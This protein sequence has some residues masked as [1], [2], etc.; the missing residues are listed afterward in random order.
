[1]TYIQGQELAKN[2]T[3]IGR[4][5]GCEICPLRH[6]GICRALNDEVLENFKKISR[7]RF[8]RQGNTI[9]HEGDESN[10]F[11]SIVFGL[12]KLSKN[13]SGGRQHIV[14]LLY[15]TAFFGQRLESHHV[16][17]AQAVSDVELCCYPR[18][19]FERFVKQHPELEHAVFEM[20]IQQLDLCRNRTLILARKNSL[21]RVASFLMMTV[22]RNPEI[23]SKPINGNSARIKLPFTRA[24]LADYLGLTL[25]TVSR[26]LSILRKRRVIELRSSRDVIVSDIGELVSAASIE[27]C[28]EQSEGTGA[29]ASN[30]YRQSLPRDALGPEPRTSSPCILEK[31][32]READGDRSPDFD[33]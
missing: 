20:T 12:V 10:Y 4:V 26:Q 29:L 8:V 17:E 14:E 22:N 21:E 2:Q 19:P 6:R 23:G 9:F 5:R 27:V 18:E 1:V 31:T 11:Y 24:E 7:R 30:R 3:A 13:L 33:R 32:G 28:S 25:E 15:P 16:C